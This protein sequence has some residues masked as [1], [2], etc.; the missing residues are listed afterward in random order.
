MRQRGSS[1][2][3]ALPLLD[4]ASVKHVSRFVQYRVL[5][6][7]V[8]VPVQYRYCTVPLSST[9]WAPTYNSYRGEP[10]QTPGEPGHTRG[11]RVCRVNVHTG[12]TRDTRA[13]TGTPIT[14][15]NLTT[16]TTRTTARRPR[17]R[18]RLNSRSPGADRSSVASPRPTQISDQEAAPSEP[19]PAATRSQSA[20]PI[21][22]VGQ[23]TIT[24]RPII[25]CLECY[26]RLPHPRLSFR[27]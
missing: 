7:T 1:P 11:C 17:N 23:C 15:T 16:I 4:R 13:H 25:K 14:K 3:G 8:P 27:W 19:D 20:S 6:G 24:H 18:G 9:K 26:R 10:V 2:G 21:K 5:Q 22:A 12:H